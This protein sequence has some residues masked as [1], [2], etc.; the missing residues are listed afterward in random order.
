MLTIDLSQ[1]LALQEALTCCPG[2]Q[3]CTCTYYTHVHACMYTHTQP[4]TPYHV[5]VCTKCLAP[6]RKVRLALDFRNRGRPAVNRDTSRL[7]GVATRYR[8]QL[9]QWVDALVRA[10]ARRAKGGR[11]PS[12]QACAGWAMGQ[13][14]W[15][16][17]LC[18]AG[19]PAVMACPGTYASERGACVFLRACKLFMP[20]Q[21][22]AL[23]WLLVWARSSLQDGPPGVKWLLVWAVGV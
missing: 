7:D 17:C 3:T 8:S 2:S 10:S 9:K 11:C 20:L 5:C 14:P 6:C 18:R 19:A 4:P 12:A 23:K 21:A 13:M 1:R 15:F 16:A 22:D